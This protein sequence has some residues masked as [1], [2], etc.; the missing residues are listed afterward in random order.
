MNGARGIHSAAEDRAPKLPHIFAN[1]FTL[2]VGGKGGS[3]IIGTSVVGPQPAAAAAG[4]A[5]AAAGEGL[6][7]QANLM[8]DRVLAGVQPPATLYPITSAAS[9]SS[10][11]AARSA[12]TPQHAM[13]SLLLPP[14][15]LLLQHRCHLRGC[16]LPFVSPFP[17]LS[18]F[19]RVGKSPAGSRAI[20]AAQVTHGLRN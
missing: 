3:T 7:C 20:I 8:R 11:A 5:A 9:K 18:G 14:L 17:L 2:Q 16:A 15:L 19:M 4:A 10:R 1:I 13:H 12:G 6:C